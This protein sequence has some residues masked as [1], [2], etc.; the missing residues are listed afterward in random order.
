M[1]LTD[2]LP[3]HWKLERK[4]T[5]QPVLH[6]GFGK[7]FSLEMS[8]LIPLKPNQPLRKAIGYKGHPLKILDITAGWGQDA[9]LLAKLGCEVTAIEKNELVFMFLD[10]LNKNPET[11]PGNLNFILD[12]SLRYLKTI[13]EKKPDVIYMDPMFQINKKSASGKNLWILQQI[14][15][16]SP[17]QTSALFEEALKKSQKRIVVKRGKREKPF[18][19]PLLCSFS[20]RAVRF[21]VF[22][23]TPE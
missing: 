2:T 15:R 16:S 5:G 19:G 6:T 20:G 12:D 21:D 17:E 13:K 23:P 1:P 22:S 4:N 11:G 3:S 18:R 7:A 9:W 8:K 10:F 14:T